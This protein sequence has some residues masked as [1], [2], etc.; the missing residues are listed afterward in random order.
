M[1]SRAADPGHEQAAVAL[2][3]GAGQRVTQPR[4]AVLARV[5]AAGTD[6]V[7]ADTVL[8]EV[9]AHHADVHRATVYRTLDALTDAGVLRHVHLDRGVRAYHLASVA[10]PVPHLH[11]QC[12]R[13][14]RVV[15]LPPDALGDAAERI[16]AAT[17]FRLDAAHAA[18]SGLCADCGG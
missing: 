4:V 3:R 15:D 5:I 12:A 10:G 17:G 8:E 14:G 11:A 16:R 2:L 13:C 1:T 6:H 7:S 9:T 18:L